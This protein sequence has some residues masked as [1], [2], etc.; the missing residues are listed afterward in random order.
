MPHRGLRPARCTRPRPRG[1]ASP[2][3]RVPRTCGV[4]AAAH[5]TRLLRAPAQ[6]G[7]PAE[8]PRGPQETRAAGHLSRGCLPRTCCCP[9]GSRDPGSR[10][11]SPGGQGGRRQLSDAR[12]V[13]SGVSLGSSLHTA[14]RCW[15]LL[16][17]QCSTHPRDLGQAAA[18]GHAAQHRPVR[19]GDEDSKLSP[20]SSR[21]RLRGQGSQAGPRAPPSLDQ[22]TS[23]CHRRQ[24][25]ALEVPCLLPR[26]AAPHPARGH[27]PGDQTH[28]L[29]ASWRWGR[30]TRGA[31]PT[32]T[33]CSAGTP[34]SG[35]A[36]RTWLPRLRW[37]RAGR[38]DAEEKPH[39]PVLP[40][41]PGR[42]AHSLGCTRPNLVSPSSVLTE[43][44]SLVTAGPALRTRTG[45][46]LG[47]EGP[48]AGTTHPG[49]THTRDQAVLPEPAPGPDRAGDG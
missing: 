25:Q 37:P 27:V 14:P 24:P 19:R 17:P 3:T 49:K 38:S 15:G 11:P 41:P 33:S 23:R 13:Q 46:L 40:Q 44:G 39:C 30:A 2:G 32:Q 9:A 18:H 21:P 35:R 34:C 47:T 4:P 10:S 5:A 48:A 43:C 22:G 12:H 1:P 20:P 16:S 7:V 8:R 45:V 42:L 36:V 28:L 29:G 26:L 6:D 31:S